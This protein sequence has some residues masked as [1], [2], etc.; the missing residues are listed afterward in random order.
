MTRIPDSISLLQTKVK[1][2]VLVHD[3]KAYEGS[4]GITLP[5]LRFSIRWIKSGQLHALAT[6]TLVPT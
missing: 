4:R 2:K 6:L 5:I 3:T 1:G